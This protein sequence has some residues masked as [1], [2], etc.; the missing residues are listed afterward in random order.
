MKRVILLFTCLLISTGFAFSQE[1]QVSGSVLDEAGEQIIGASVIVK[2][3][4][5]IGTTTN[6]EGKFTLSVPASAEALI[7][8]Y[9]GYSDLEVKIGGG[10]ITATLQQSSQELDEVIVVGYGTAKKS[11]FTGSTSVIKGEKL[12]KGQTSNVSKALEGAVAGVQTSS[13]TG[14]P[15]A[16][17]NIR[18]RGFGSISANQNPLIVVD[19][20][21]YE[22]SLN[23][24][25][26]Q[27]IETLNVLKDAAANS[28]YGARGSNGVILITTKKGASGKTRISFDGRFGQNSRA[29]PAYSVVTDPADYY[30]LTWEANR[31]Q[32]VASGVSPLAAGLDASSKLISDHLGYNV[33]KGVD[34]LSLID[35]ITGRINPAATAK[36]WSDDWL[37][38]PFRNGLRQEYNV[39]VSGGTEN[40]S[41][42]MSIGYLNDEGYVVSSDFE[43][44]SI[45]AKVDQKFNEHFKAGV[46]V[47]YSK[48]TTDQ[49]VGSTGGTN[50]SNI[51]MFTQKI[52]PIYPIYKYDLGTGAPIYNLNGSHAYD[53]GS[54]N[55]LNGNS[56]S[57]T[58]NFAAEQNPMFVL[59]NDMDGFSYDNLTSRAY[60]EIKFLKDFTFT[61]NIA[62]DV[63]NYNAK[64]FNNPIIGNG[65][66]YGGIGDRLFDRYEA[67]NAN[68]LLNYDRE[69]GE[70]KINVLLGHETKVDEE[71][72]FYGAKMQF[73]DPFNSELANAGSMSSLTSYTS[74]YVLEGYLSRIEYNYAD[75]YYLSGSFRRDASSKFHPDDRWGN[76][77][78]VGAAWRIK[79]ESFLRDLDLL[80]SLRIK[81]S[82]GTQGNDGI[83]GNNLYQDQF[84]ITSDGTYPSPVFTYRGARVTWEKSNNL[85]V[86]LETK[87]F[88]IVGLNADFFIK[89]TKD[90]LYQKPLSP[91]MG[92]PTWIWDN[93]IDM[94]N[95]GFEVEL[96]VDLIKTNDIKWDIALNVTTIKNELTKLPDDKKDPKGY[97]DGSYW[98]KIGGSLYDFYTYDFVGIDETTGKSVWNKE[99]PVDANDDGEQDTDAQ[100]NLVFKTEKTSDYAEA[101][102]YETGKSAVPDFYG[103]LS[104]NLSAYGID[105]SIQTAFQV[106]GY[107]M[108]SEYQ[109]L[110]HGGQSD[111]TNWHTDIFNRWTPTNTQSD[112]PILS[113]GDQNTDASSDRWL[114]DA[115]S[116]NLRNITLGYTLP[117]RL[118]GKYDIESLRFYVSGDNIWFGSARKGLDPRH[119][120]SGT[121]YTGVYSALR[122]VSVGISAAF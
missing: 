48:T 68:Q 2:G 97:V 77:W 10:D 54:N 94:K 70:H 107:V 89:E 17:A 100:G 75:K 34:D 6:I 28:M 116:F 23:S 64:S 3:H 82:Y 53:F 86:G 66:A 114:T 122:T 20:V 16:G 26:P 69:I 118:T 78:S 111:A 62:Y 46:N 43:R 121:V 57:R 96:I 63:F 33:Y 71:R 92:S 113:T 88:D 85:N 95:T 36:K 106:G 51:F 112:I 67:V 55:M 81:A 65:A 91:S 42:Y 32:L 15:G 109:G 12:T 14:Q 72:Y 98:R 87:L 21:P 41:A 11:T 35:P 74:K 79:E 117:K 25:A 8:K 18:I 4:P 37:K 101:S 108:D 120:F 102:R 29:I 60:A 61:A 105:F 49:I 5:T 40:T 22:G 7:I 99:V 104:T 38:D 56:T 110:M 93:Q 9:L 47:S 24:I 19:G 103:G 119:S 52:A 76:F 84:S 1:K 83:S 59:E 31:N 30:E 115:S 73:Y 90:M 13:A 80:N 44:V 39:N 58:R 45:R 50:Y 27:D